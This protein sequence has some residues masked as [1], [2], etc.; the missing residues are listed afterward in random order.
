MKPPMEGDHMAKR[1]LSL[2]VIG[3][4]SSQASFA[5]VPTLALT[6]DTN[7]AITNATDTMR[8]K[9][10]NAE[11]LIKRVIA[12][13]TFRERV[14]NHTYNGQKTYVDNGG[15]TNEQIYQKILEGAERLN[16]VANN[17]MDIEIEM[18]YTFTSTVG[19]TTST[20][21]KI[22]A[23]TK[24]YNNYTS[25]QITGN[26]T[27]EWLH[28]LGF[29][30]ASSYSTSRDY[31]VPYAIGT[32]M[33][34]IAVKL[35]TSST[36]PTSPNEYF[37]AAADVKLSSTSSNVTLNWSPATSSNGIE[38]YKVY[39]KLSTSSTNYLQTTTK[40]LSFTQTKPTTNAVYY[41][42]AIDNSG[43]TVNSSEV[44]YIKLTAPTNVKLAKTTS[45]INLTW[46]AAKASAGI[47]EYKIYRRLSSSST[48]YL[49]ATTTNLSF[50]QS[51]PSSSAYYYV[52]AYDKNG[53]SMKSSEVKYTR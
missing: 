33:R 37:T 39:R 25:A 38:E 27:H 47:K 17:A 36:N 18:Y 6:F 32:I 24:F 11:E 13:D 14:I 1:L 49:Q 40:N 50:S 53:V 16:K 29:S 23:N 42:K 15:Y 46:D 34:E 41:I 20:S 5:E 45:S 28:K 8:A 43:K 52:K 22:Y 7:V 4:I 35:P 9:I 44:S 19:Y 48:N 3:A 10:V 30:H 51:K 31:S 26:M 12:T 2:A 21:P